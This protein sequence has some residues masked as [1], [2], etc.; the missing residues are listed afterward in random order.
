MCSETRGEWEGRGHLSGVPSKTL[1]CFFYSYN[2]TQSSSFCDNRI[3]I[4]FRFQM[5]VT[6]TSPSNSIFSEQWIEL[7]SVQASRLS[8]FRPYISGVKAHIHT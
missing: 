7:K 3:Q 1:V 6:K 5:T 8:R 4:T 2:E